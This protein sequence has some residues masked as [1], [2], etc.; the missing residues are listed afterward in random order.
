MRPSRIQRRC[1]GL[2]TCF[3]RSLGSAQQTLPADGRAGAAAPEAC[4]CTACV[5]TRANDMQ[6]STPLERQI[7][8][9]SRYEGR[10]FRVAIVLL[11]IAPIVLVTL[12]V[13]NLH[14]AATHATL[15]NT[16]LADVFTLWLNGPLPEVS[17]QVTSCSRSRVLTQR[18]FSSPML[19]LR[20]S[21][22][23]H[24][25]DDVRARESFSLC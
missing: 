24:C 21:L 4:R 9:L 12:A 5:E 11:C 25:G 17:T 16:S 7:S 15:A 10:G 19:Q 1:E 6:P 13:L 2:L 22:Y 14:A 18:S 8:G 23:L 3:G 20:S